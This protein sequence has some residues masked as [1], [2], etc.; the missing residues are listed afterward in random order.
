[1]HTAVGTGLFD[2]GHRDGPAEQALLQHPLGLAVLADGSVA[3]ADTYNRAVRR[4]DP[5]TRALSTL[6]RDVDEPHDVLVLD[7]E[8][9][10]LASAGHEVHALPVRDELVRADARTVVRRPSDVAPGPVRLHVVFTPPP[11]THLDEREGP[12]TRLEVSSTP[13]GLLLAGAGTANPVCQVVR[14][15]W[16]VP[17]RLVPDGPGELE[18][19]MGGLAMQDGR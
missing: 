7:G 3:V 15:E 17:L 1:M 6:A 2:F 18:L 12:A 8:L 14:Q 4:Y 11:G 9:L 16:G 5:A 10:V 13:P 19:V